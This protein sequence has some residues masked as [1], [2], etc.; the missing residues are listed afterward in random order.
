[1][2]VFVDSPVAL[3]RYIEDLSQIDVAPDFRPRRLQVA[4]ERFAKSVG[5]RLVIP[6]KEKHLPDAVGLE[7]G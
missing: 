2:L 4:V 1:M 5:G 6:Q 3:A 7:E